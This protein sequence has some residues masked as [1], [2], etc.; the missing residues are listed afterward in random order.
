VRFSSWKK[1]FVRWDQ[2]S[3]LF[4]CAQA[5]RLAEARP[6]P[7]RGLALFVASVAAV[8]SLHTVA[9]GVLL[10]VLIALVLVQRS[11]SS[12]LVAPWGLGAALLTHAVWGA[13]ES[14]GIDAPPPVDLAEA[15]RAAI[16]LD[17]IS[18]MMRITWYDPP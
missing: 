16:G 13:S 12:L 6:L 11:R 4:A 1:E 2:T 3:L 18:L 9:A 10:L 5:F 7:R 8:G 14:V 17:A 15:L